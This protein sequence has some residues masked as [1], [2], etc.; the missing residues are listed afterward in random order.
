MAQLSAEY[1]DLAAIAR[2]SSTA[3]LPWSGESSTFPFPPYLR[4]L[5]DADTGVVDRDALEAR[6]TFL[7][8]H[9]DV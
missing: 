8:D 4:N 1:A 6:L 3:F 7:A 9:V 2:C 5:V